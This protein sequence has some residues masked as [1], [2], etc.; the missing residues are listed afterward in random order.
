MPNKMYFESGNTVHPL[1]ANN[2][3]SALFVTCLA[4][5]RQEVLMAL[6]S[7]KRDWTSSVQ[8]LGGPANLTLSG[9][10][11]PPTRACLLYF[12]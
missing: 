9:P 2:G 7:S 12:Q 11:G 3:G 6:L 4:T 5:R 10:C 8:I 1:I